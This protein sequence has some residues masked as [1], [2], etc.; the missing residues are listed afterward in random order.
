MNLQGESYL[1]K[2]ILVTSLVKP[3]TSVLVHEFIFMSPAVPMK[4]VCM[5]V[6]KTILYHTAL[7]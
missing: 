4:P 5:H 3:V 7:N 6:A 2:I 1:Y